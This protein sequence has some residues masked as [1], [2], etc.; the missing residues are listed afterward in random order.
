ML[1]VL[2]RETE[3]AEM[4]RALNY[5]NAEIKISYHPIVVRYTFCHA[6]FSAV[7]YVLINQESFI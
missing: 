1:L 2:S 3:A 6:I 7:S 4:I 5:A